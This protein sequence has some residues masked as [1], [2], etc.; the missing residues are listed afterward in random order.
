MLA[1]DDVLFFLW[2]TIEPT[3]GSSRANTTAT[4]CGGNRCGVRRRGGKKSDGGGGAG[5]TTLFVFASDF[6]ALPMTRC[7]GGTRGGSFGSGLTGSTFRA[8]RFRCLFS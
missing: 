2:S 8:G 1:V 5:N 6:A 3:S 4:T 7:F